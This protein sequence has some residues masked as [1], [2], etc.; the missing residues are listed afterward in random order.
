MKRRGHSTLENRTGFKIDDIHDIES[1]LFAGGGVNHFK[2]G[3]RGDIENVWLVRSRKVAR[4]PFILT[5][6]TGYIGLLA[7]SLKIEIF[8]P[9]SGKISP[10][11]SLDDLIIIQ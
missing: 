11:S 5:H 3:K 2:L 4:K 6:F 9:I 7:K 1:N 8:C 10:Y